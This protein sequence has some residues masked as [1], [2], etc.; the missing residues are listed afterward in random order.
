M[1]RRTLA[2]LVLAVALATGSASAQSIGIFGD[3]SG[4]TCNIN[5]PAGVPSNLW[6]L[7][8]P[9][10]LG[11]ITGAE[12]KIQHPWTPGVDA[13]FINT[14]NP[15]ANVALGDPWGF[16]G[17]NVA[18]PVCQ[19]GGVVNLFAVTMIPLNP[20]T[21]A[22]VTLGIVARTPPNNPAFDCQLLTMCDAPEYTSICVGGGE[23]FVNSSR[24][25]TVAVESTTWS[26][27][28]SLY[29]N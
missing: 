16:I 24:N 23:A 19:I 25:C 26:Q 15:A 4:A 18:F 1:K 9:G 13:L 22:N 11:G 28:K 17:A 10:P 12:F 21:T 20:V 14:P 2:T 3:P 29:N 6:I 27:M 5:A 8:I 7:A